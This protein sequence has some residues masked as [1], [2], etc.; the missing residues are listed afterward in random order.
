MTPESNCEDRRPYYMLY[1]SK[2]K[3]MLGFGVIIF[4]K[5]S[6]RSFPNRKWFINPPSFVAPVSSPRQSQL[7]SSLSLHLSSS[8]I[9]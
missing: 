9:D 2:T 5:T 7:I 3:Q 1:D 4:G 6:Q 8:S